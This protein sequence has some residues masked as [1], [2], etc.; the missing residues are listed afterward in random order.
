MVDDSRN[1]LFQATLD[2]RAQVAST[3]SDDRFRVQPVHHLEGL[4]DIGVQVSRASGGGVVVAHHY[5][6][7]LF[8]PRTVECFA[9]HYVAVLR[10]FTMPLWLDV[11]TWRLPQ[12]SYLL[13]DLEK[14]T[15]VSFDRTVQKVAPRLAYISRPILAAGPQGL[16]VLSASIEEHHCSA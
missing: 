10:A 15:P 9:A 5:C 14:A 8:Q 12:A 4:V 3:V 7:D 2:Y 6:T 16:E 1:P 13:E 11:Q